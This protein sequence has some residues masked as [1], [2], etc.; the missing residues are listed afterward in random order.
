MK[1][2]L[3]FGVMA[4]GLVVA[5]ISHATLLRTPSLIVTGNGRSY[6]PILH[7][8]SKGTTYLGWTDGRR[9]KFDLYL[10]RSRD[11]GRTWSEEIWI[12]AAKMPAV[13]SAGLGF[14][15]GKAAALHAVWFATHAEQDVRVM[16]AMSRDRGATW[17]SPQQLNASLG[18]GYEPK[19]AGDG[20]GHLY[21][22]WYERRASNEPQKEIAGFKLS[23]PQLYDV[24]FTASDD[25]GANWRPPVR[26][27]PRDDSPTSMRPQIAYGGAGHV[28]VLWQE[29]EIG[30]SSLGVYVAS[31]PD[32]GKTWPVRGLRIDRGHEGTSSPRLAA[33]S[34]GHVYAA[35]NDAREQA[36]AVYFNTSADHGKTWLTEDIRLGQAAA[37]KMHALPPSLAASANG[38]VFV[39]WID[40]R[41]RPASEVNPLNKSDVFVVASTDY[42]KSWGPRDMRLNTPPPGSARAS[43]QTIVSDPKGRRVAVAWSD[44]RSGRE[45][46]Y[47][48]YSTDGGRSWL[49]TEA[50]VDAD[51][52]PDQHGLAP[53]LSME[54]NDSLVVAWE[55][56]RGET[57]QRSMERSLRDIRVRRLEIRTK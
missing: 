47:A 25:D 13:E 20:A 6:L 32:H 30:Q 54:D 21:V 14:A 33:D 24:Y 18:L 9:A 1:R 10:V 37:G 34:A 52:G 51:A 23:A 56:G 17:S 27:N 2:I 7:R 3:P 57:E 44:N 39:A 50:H 15:E 41:N 16:H 12:D 4:L 49:K 48:T 38:R 28:Y 35:W 11:G 40:S 42:G 36:F 53:V 43:G 19:I 29:R 22:T 8:D 26:L 55:V 31:S 5:T 45:A 46:I